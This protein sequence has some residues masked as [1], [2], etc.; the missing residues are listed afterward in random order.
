MLLYPPVIIQ[1]DCQQAVATQRACLR[2]HYFQALCVLRKPTL[3]WSPDIKALNP[4]EAVY[5]AE[6]YE[7]LV[8]CAQGWCCS[9][10]AKGPRETIW[11]ILE[12]A[13]CCTC[14][15]PMG[16]GVR[17][18]YGVPEWQ[19]SDSLESE[20]ILLWN[21][22]DV[23]IEKISSWLNCGL[24]LK[25]THKHIDLFCLSQSPVAAYA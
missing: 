5:V 12:P 3:V 15:R 23:Y 24:Y 21:K 14:R 22:T 6:G 13:S 11:C 16:L 17:R 7:A 9:M 25:K 1:R 19:G 18:G 10:L 2:F 4:A 20:S 8:L